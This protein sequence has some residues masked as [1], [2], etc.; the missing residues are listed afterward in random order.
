[1]R[2]PLVFGGSM[3]TQVL[4]SLGAL[5][6]PLED[7][8]AAHNRGDHVAGDPCFIRNPDHPQS[9]NRALRSA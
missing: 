1:M 3:A 4:G 5:A 7:G 8:M 6:G 2:K 9:A